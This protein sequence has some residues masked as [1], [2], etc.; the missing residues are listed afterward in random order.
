MVIHHIRSWISLYH[1]EVAVFSFPV[2]EGCITKG[3]LQAA[4]QK[5]LMHAVIT[6]TLVMIIYHR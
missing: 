6:S 1:Y 5:N 2:F 3:A 4:L